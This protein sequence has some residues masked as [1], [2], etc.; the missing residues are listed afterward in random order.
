MWPRTLR[1][2][3]WLMDAGRVEPVRDWLTDW[4][5]LD[6]RW[7]PDAVG[8]W[9]EIR[10]VQ[11]VATTERYGRAVMPVTHAAVSRVARDTDTFSSAWFSVNLPGALRL[12]APPITA[13]PPDHDRFRRLLLPAFHPKRIQLMEPMLRRHCR[14]LIA[15][16]G[17]TRAADAS[18][19][20][21]RHLPV[22]GICDLVGLPEH[23]ADRYRDWI[24]RIFQLAPRDNE[25][26]ERVG[27]EA[28]DFVDELLQDRLA[29]PTDDLLTE[30]ATAPPAEGADLDPE[31][32]WQLRVGCVLLLIVAGI[33][34]TW[35]AIGWAIWHLAQHP[36]DVQR[37]VAVDDAH[38]LWD[39]ATEEVLRYYAPVSMAR[40]ATGP[41]DVGG[42]PVHHGDQVLLPFTAANHDPAVFDAPEEFRID[43]V[44]NRHAA[45]GLG[46]HRCLGS[47][48]ARL[49][50]TVAMQEWFR[51]FP[52][53]TLDPDRPPTWANGQVR[54]PTT[55]PVLVGT[56]RSTASSAR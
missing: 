50:L 29:N 44:R 9:N 42:C 4:D 39:S 52:E 5:W 55:L 22:R 24:H 10:D 12:L 19:D 43:R 2:G 32:D 54:G 35:K 20:Y 37:L 23:E 1:G 3:R 18:I 15:E 8:V 17:D 11:P 25:E 16:I 13:D 28:L 26:L 46:I 21:A 36:A 53:T 7:G 51:A 49:E 30:I 14:R 45:F 33:D 6:D 56:N 41:A 31:L 34:T 40:K 47:N 27:R 38:P 48:L